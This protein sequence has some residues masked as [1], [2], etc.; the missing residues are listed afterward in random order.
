MV[1]NVNI[2]RKPS[3]RVD[4]IYFITPTDESVEALVSDFSRR[5]QLQHKDVHV[6]FSSAVEAHQLDRIRGCK[7]LVENLVTLK[8]INLE[9]FLFPDSRSFT[10]AQDSAL[11]SFFG[12]TADFD[13]EYKHEISIMAR[14]LATVF[15]TLK[16]YPSIRYRAALPPGDEYPPGLESRLLVSQRLAVE[17]TEILEEMQRS[18]HIPERETCEL[19]IMDR[20]F[21]TVAPIIHEWTY[22]AMIHD[23]LEDDKSLRGKIYSYKSQ[24]Q[25]GKIET[26]EH[27]LNENDSLFSELRHKHFAAAS[28][29]ITSELDELRAKSRMASVPGGVANMDLR[30][31]AR[32]VQALPEYHDRLTQLGAHIELASALNRLIDMHRLTDLG[33]LEQDLVFG[34][35][36][37]KEVISF[38]STNQMLPVADK[39]RLLLC[40]SATHQEKLD[41]VRQAQWQKV[42]RITEADMDVIINLEYLGIPV[43]KRQ[44]PGLAGLTFG[45]RRRRAVRKE[46]EQGEDEQQFSLIRFTPLLT[47]IIEDANSGR[48]SQEEYPFVRPPSSPSMSGNSISF[49]NST[50]S[51]STIGSATNTPKKA[52]ASFRTVRTN[53]S[54]WTQKAAIGNS[55]V[56]PMPGSSATFGNR[57]DRNTQIRGGK[58][59][60]YV[61]GGMT[62]SELRAVHR[63]SI[64]LG[65]DVYIGSTNVVTPSKFMQQIVALGPNAENITSFDGIESAPLPI[66]N[67]KRK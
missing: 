56:N 48:L 65:R 31:M 40:Y 9:Y 57:N 51:T 8:E 42:A 29:Q 33:K 53:T 52:V 17:L 7:K 15:S 3:P 6:F 11:V 50:E 39:I 63:S 58:I 54:T 41:S 62:Y 27:T 5:G 60:T 45:R 25:G 28:M 38:L 22:E 55:A 49:G 44:K 20:G 36:T 21:D 30:G 13:E 67:Y 32:L 1:D 66:Q 46:R 47:E 2:P 34:D 59:F 37:S 24:M 18:G 61:I 43:C 4:G 64:K 26:K 19:I 35:A 12:A 23:L 10:T 14:R 16:E